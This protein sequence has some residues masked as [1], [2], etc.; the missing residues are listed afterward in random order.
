MELRFTRDK[1]RPPTKHRVADVVESGTLYGHKYSFCAQVRQAR[2]AYS[3]FHDVSRKNWELVAGLSRALEERA[4]GVKV[5][6]TG[7][8][9]PQKEVVSNKELPE[10][11]HEAHD[12]VVS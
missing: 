6:T 10:G 4:G 9:L 3:R 5:R 8:R 12:G 11:V 2:C 7:V 1:Q